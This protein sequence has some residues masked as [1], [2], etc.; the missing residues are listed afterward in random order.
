MRRQ[1]L[2]ILA[3]LWIG[4]AARSAEWL[5][6]AE[7]AQAKA[8]QENKFV[9][10]DFTGS[11]WCGW[12]KKLKREVFD[13]PEFVQFAQTKL[14]LVEVD[15][16]HAQTLALLQQRANAKLQ[17]TYRVTGYPTLVVLDPTGREVAR[18]GYVSGGPSA[19]I[20]RFEQAT[21]ARQVASQPAAQHSAPE[22]EPIRKPVKWTPPPP[23]TPINYGPLALKSISGPKER[24]IVLINNAS[25]MV[26]EKAKVRTQDHEVV[27]VCKEIRE[28]SVLITCDG[29]EMELTLGKTATGPRIQ[30][31]VRE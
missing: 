30:T 7:A 10:L 2:L 13:T 19:F 23:P 4:D 6:D 31:A 22:P 11:D 24:R 26:G 3:S 29:K 20:S 21:R 27:V 5:T 1:I 28:D 16:P 12:C 9:M 8:K 25:M 18:L 14:V 17:S 15:F